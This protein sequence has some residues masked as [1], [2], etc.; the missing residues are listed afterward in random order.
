MQ[1]LQKP[2]EGLRFSKT[3]VA[4]SCEQPCGCWELNPGP[5]QEQA[6]F[7]RVE[8]LLSSPRIHIFALILLNVWV[9]FVLFISYLYVYVHTCAH[10][11]AMVCRWRSEDDPQ[12]LV[13]S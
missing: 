9:F 10:A 12:E 11:Q 4:E 2:K 6:A 1:L 5:L 7:S 13:L 8:L 3:G